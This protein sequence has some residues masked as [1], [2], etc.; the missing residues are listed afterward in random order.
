MLQEA[1]KQGC[2]QQVR[3]LIQQ[4]YQIPELLQLQRE[5]RSIDHTNPDHQYTDQDC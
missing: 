4:N 1:Q 5:A 2:F 3:D